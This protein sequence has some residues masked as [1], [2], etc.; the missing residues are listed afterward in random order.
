VEDMAVDPG[1]WSGRKV[2]VTG[3]TGFKGSWLCL[4]LAAAGA[5]VAGYSDGIPTQPSLF[6]TASVGDVVAST[7]ADVRDRDRLEA[8]LRDARPDVAFHLAAQPLVRRSFAEPILTFETNVLG[9]VNLLEAVCA[10]ESVRA[11]VVVTT[12]KVYAEAL[13]RRHDEDDPLGGKDPYSSSKACAELVVAAYRQS[14]FGGDEA[15]AVATVRAGN[16]IGGGDWA[17]DRLVPDVVAALAAGR[18]V[19]LRY[20]DA[21]RPWQHVLNPLEGYLVLAERL[22]RDR[23]AARA[24]NFGPD[25]ADSRSVGFVVDRIASLWGA[26]LELG[27]A[28][29]QPPEAHSLELDST[30]AQEEL[31]WRP[32][33]DLD[34]GLRA[35]VDWY[36]RHLAGEDGRHLTLAQI[37]EFLASPASAPVTA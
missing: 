22:W 11:A 3:H 30:R 15:A 2:F 8:A 33:W 31:G 14:Y 5:E 29:E 10:T 27:A 1:F 21:I 4:W 25:A 34:Q 20:P 12:D 26:E 24:W 19:E 36:R 37:E 9:T 18:A 17:A 35:T 16:V 6:E 7:F 28:R 13:R 23:A 32:R